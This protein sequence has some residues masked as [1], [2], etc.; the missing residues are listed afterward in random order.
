MS[1]G[2]S[3]VGAAAP[4]AVG[5]GRAGA[6]SSRAERSEPSSPGLGKQGTQEPLGCGGARAASNGSL[7]QLGVEA[8]AGR[9][10][11][12]SCVPEPSEDFPPR[13][14]GLTGPEGDRG[15]GGSHITKEGVLLTEEGYPWDADVVRRLLSYCA[16]VGSL[17]VFV[18]ALD[19]ATE[20][21]AVRGS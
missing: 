19:I 1:E 20:V 17:V 10:Y 15:L 21:L 2:G 4:A 14:D 3:G 11:G 16:A 9:A 7:P 18:R 8:V 13:G 5:Q 6:R 12:G